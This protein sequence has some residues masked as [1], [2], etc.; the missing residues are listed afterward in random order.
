M[1]EIS[2]FQIGELVALAT[3]VSPCTKHTHSRISR[4]SFSSSLVHST[5]QTLNVSAYLLSSEG[6][7]YIRINEDC[8]V[9]DL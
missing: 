7:L 6:H 2:S 4:I 3:D 9:S 1:K 8:P 5:I